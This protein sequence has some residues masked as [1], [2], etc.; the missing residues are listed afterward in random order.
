MKNAFSLIL[1]ACFVLHEL[2][3]FALLFGHVRKSLAETGLST[4]TKNW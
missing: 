1:K 2:E 3:I 4:V